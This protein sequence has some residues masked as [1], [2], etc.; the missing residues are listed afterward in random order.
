MINEITVKE[1]VFKVGDEIRIRLDD[2]KGI[3]KEIQYSGHFEEW[4]KYDL[5]ICWVN[6]GITIRTSTEHFFEF[7]EFI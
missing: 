5:M 6:D 2:D 1:T 3:I 4:R 7:M